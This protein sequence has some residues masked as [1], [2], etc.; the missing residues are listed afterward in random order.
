MKRYLFWPVLLVA[1]GMLGALMVG[2]VTLADRHLL[3][4]AIPLGGSELD[5]NVWPD[6]VT[7]WWQGGQRLAAF[8][9]PLRWLLLAW[10]VV[11]SYWL[12]GVIGR[13]YRAP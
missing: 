6:R 9:N 12:T 10:T 8:P 1:L 2:A 7:V 3:L 13:R 11:V 4:V 5:V